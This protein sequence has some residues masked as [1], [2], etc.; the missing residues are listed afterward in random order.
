MAA[1]DHHTELIPYT[2]HE[3][4]PPDAPPWGDSLLREYDLRLREWQA[5]DQRD[6]PGKP[7]EDLERIAAAKMRGEPAW[8]IMLMEVL[9]NARGPLIV[10]AC[11]RMG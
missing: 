11:L 10:D 4:P 3:P 8:Y 6:R 1:S 9:P 5:I 2:P 7:L